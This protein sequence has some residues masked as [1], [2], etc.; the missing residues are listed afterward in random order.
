MKWKELLTR[1]RLLFSL[2]AVATIATIFVLYATM[3]TATTPTSSGTN[4]PALPTET[5][6]G[7]LV[8]AFGVTGSGTPSSSFTANQLVGNSQVRQGR[9]NVGFAKPFGGSG[10]ATPQDDASLT[11]QLADN[12]NVDSSPP[13]NTDADHVMHG[14]DGKGSGTAPDDFTKILLANNDYPKYDHDFQAFES[15]VSVGGGPESI[16]SDRSSGDLNEPQTSHTPEPAS[17]LLLGSALVG[18]AVFARKLK[19]M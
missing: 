10:L 7:D 14:S 16:A 11:T 13:T 12:S 6:V 2:V 18:F 4:I 8:Q 15:H 19:K 1:K 17:M 3:H 5:H 9:G